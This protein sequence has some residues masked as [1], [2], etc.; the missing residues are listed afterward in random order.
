MAPVN[1]FWTRVSTAV[2]IQDCHKSPFWPL[3]RAKLSCTAIHSTVAKHFITTIHDASRFLKF[4]LSEFSA[5]LGSAHS[6]PDYNCSEQSQLSWYISSVDKSALL[7]LWHRLCVYK[8]FQVFGTLLTSCVVL[9]YC[10]LWSMCVM[11]TIFT[12]LSFI[13]SLE[14][15]H[16]V[17]CKGVKVVVIIVEARWVFCVWAIN[18]I[19]LWDLRDGA[20]AN[21]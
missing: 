15:V 4:T 11:P 17:C 21:T 1:S 19:W 5:R 7:F 6:M 16:T 20:E 2:F 8:S 10:D 12:S 18:F 13:D 14:E 3:C 9:V